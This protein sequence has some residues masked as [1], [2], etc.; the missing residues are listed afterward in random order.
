M[1]KLGLANIG[2]QSIELEIVEKWEPEKITFLG[3]TVFFSVDGTFFSM[4]RVDFMNIF[5]D[6]CTKIK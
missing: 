6:F 2:E 4:E 1:V 3:N 5:K